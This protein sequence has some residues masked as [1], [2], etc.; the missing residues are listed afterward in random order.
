MIGTSLQCIFWPRFSWFQSYIQKDSAFQSQKNCM[1]KCIHFDYNILQQKCVN[2][3][4]L[5]NLVSS[6][7]IFVDITL[8]LSI[9]RLNA[10]TQ[11]KVLAWASEGRDGR[12]HRLTL[13]PA[14]QGHT[15]PSSITRKIVWLLIKMMLKLT[16]GGDIWQKKIISLV[17]LVSGRR[18]L[19]CIS[20]HG[21]N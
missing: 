4:N 20:R 19:W 3:Q 7:G 17:V 1:K 5:Q 14:A 10:W 15:D 11:L 13:G 8:C 2:N 18:G 16:I 6:K 12:S 21:F 9:L